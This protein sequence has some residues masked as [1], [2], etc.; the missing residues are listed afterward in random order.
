MIG[1]GFVFN[2]ATVNAQSGDTIT[3][4]GL[5]GF[6][7][8][9]QTIAAGSCTTQA[10]PLFGS[11]AAASSY[12]WVIPANVTGTFF[13]RCNPH[14][15]SGMRGTINVTAPPPPPCIGDANN[16]DVVNFADVTEILANFGG[17]GPAGD[18]DH[19]GD[20]EFADVT[21]VLANFGVPCP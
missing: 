8:V 12:S 19:D 18:A 1:P 11:P 6:H 10:S 20:V 17:T 9:T 14:C 3:W 16:D 21:A 13:Y 7:T 2:P 5:S 15:G 4:M